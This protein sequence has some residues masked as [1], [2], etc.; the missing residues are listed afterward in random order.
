[1]PSALDRIIDGA[2]DPEVSTSNL[3]RRALA[4]AHRLRADPVKD[5]AQRE[6]SGYDGVNEVDLPTYRRLRAAG[7]KAH[8]TGP[9]GASA[10]TV[11][12]E[13]D[14]P[15]DFFEPWFRIS[16]RQP[17]PELESYSTSEGEVGLPWPAVALVR[18]NELISENRAV[19]VGGHVLFS[20]Q[21]IV[22]KSTLTGVLEAVRTEVMN[23][24][25]E[26]QSAA[27]SAGEPGGPTVKD[28][29]MVEHA[30]ST[31][32]TNIYGGAPTLAQGTRVSQTVTVHA[33]DIVTLTQAAKDVGLCEEDVSTYVEAVLA[34]RNDPDKSKLSS[35]VDKVRG[36]TIA[37]GSGI[38]GDCP[39]F[40]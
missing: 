13:L 37:L 4:T 40:G 14:A 28:D 2:S 16:F 11:L 20:A 17:V 5:W 1:M 9:F 23:L 32:I 22:P 31:F 12:T 33:G 24:A 26:L 7:V 3:L 29:P 39:G 10:T 25:L 6:L 36:G 8:W 38:A 19:H 18:W 27:D 34:A 30:V 35:F 21:M 15:E